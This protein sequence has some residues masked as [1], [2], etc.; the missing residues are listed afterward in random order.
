MPVEQDTLKHVQSI[1]AVITKRDAEDIRPDHRL[2]AD[3]GLDSLQIVEVTTKLQ[4]A[5]GKLIDDD[6]LNAEGATVGR[7]AQIAQQG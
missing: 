1:I 3:L 4:K 6:L 7:C 5:V 2:V